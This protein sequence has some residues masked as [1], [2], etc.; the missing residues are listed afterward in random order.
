MLGAGLGPAPFPG[1][2]RAARRR[3]QKMR[4]PTGIKPAATRTTSK[5]LLVIRSN[6]FLDRSITVSIPAIMAA[7]PVTAV[8]V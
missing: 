5:G 4:T 7:M 2:P 6:T 1:Q 8:S 3:E